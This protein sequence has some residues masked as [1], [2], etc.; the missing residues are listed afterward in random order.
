MRDDEGRGAAVA[1][2]PGPRGP[3]FNR[4]QLAALPVGAAVLLA[5][6]KLARAHPVGDGPSL[7]ERA[8]IDDLMTAYVWAYDCSD[9]EGFVGLFVDDDP[10][11]VG[12]GTPH[13]GKQ[14]LADWFAY[15]MNIRDGENGQWL[16][17]ALHH[18]YRRQ[19]ANWLVYSYATHFAFDVDDGSYAVRSLG[20]FV[21]ELVPSHTGYLFRRFSITHWDR[22][23]VPWEKPLPWAEA[24]GL[25][26]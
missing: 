17:Q 13:R 1:A 14:A 9:V 7:E 20:Y 8:A 21:S 4:R 3:G 10:L 5:G 24:D 23:T 25:A 19:G 11:V 15:L 18:V 26:A 2:L 12:L 16:H 22:T 6:T